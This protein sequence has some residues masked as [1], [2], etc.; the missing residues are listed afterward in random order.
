MITNAAI[1]R[2]DD[3]RF[4]LAGPKIDIYVSRGRTTLPIAQVP[5]LL[6]GDKVRMKVDLPATQLNPLLLIVA[7]VRDTTNEPPDNWF[8][9]IE[10][11]RQPPE[12][13]T[14]V[15]P[16][17]AQRALLF[18]A[19]ETGG[20]FKTLRS[21]VKGNPGVF[22]R[23]DEDL[24]KASFE[25]QRIERYL[26]GMQPVAQLETAVIQARSA[27]LATALALKPNAACFKQPVEDQV[28]CLTQVSTPLLLDDGHAQT[29]A[30]AISTGASSNFI[31]EAA[32]TDNGTY[33]AYVGTLVDLVHLVSLLRT[34]QYRY[35]PAI[36]FPKG[37]TLNL[38]LNAPPSFNNPKSV[39]V[40]GLP[41]IQSAVFPP[42]RV[43]TPLP[44]L[45]MMKPSTTLSLLGA[46]L[47]FS[48]A[49]AHDLT[50]DI[51]HGGAQSRISLTPDPIAG[52]LV[53]TGIMLQSQPG[54]PRPG[55]KTKVNPYITVGGMLHGFWGFDTLDGLRLTV[56]PVPGR[57]WKLTGTDAAIAGLDVHITMEGEGT[58]CIKEITLENK[59]DK[60]E[61]V[62]FKNTEAP[63][64]PSAINLQIPLA[65]HQPGAYSLVIQ[66]YG[67][68]R[69]DTLPLTVYSGAVHFDHL[70]KHP[71]DNMV[72]LFGKGLNSVF[73]ITLG[74][75]VFTT[76][77]L[78]GKDSGRLELYASGPA[79]ETEAREAAV[80]LND[81]RVMTVRAV[82]A[83]DGSELQLVSMDS[84]PNRL[85]DE[86]EVQLDAKKDIALHGTL[87][88]V[89]Q[90]VGV[91]PRTQTVEVATAD[92]SV[93]TMLSLNT[94]RLIL[95]DDHT[96]VASLDLGKA[97]GESA[98]GT[99]RMRAVPGDGTF[100]GW[101]TLGTLVRTP[102]IV[103]VRCSEIEV[104]TCVISGRQ[105]FLA[106]GFDTNEDLS[107]EVIV[108]EGFDEPTFSMPIGAR[109]ETLY[110]RLRDDPH[111]V[112]TF[113]I[114][115]K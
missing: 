47:V 100:G 85:K 29:V 52:G 3:A 36:S 43:P 102:H 101:I 42:W 34:A 59:T 58:A 74:N 83:D 115:R 24:N 39:I 84:V 86:I 28:D 80:K 110:I 22:I 103:A 105:L 15:V 113:R 14:I 66:Q 41:V 18:V 4:D 68:P 48:T 38:K 78:Q 89:V 44:A 10:T 61:T 69:K 114:P 63:S 71:D 17:G 81:G 112:A 13:T 87:N 65:H 55:M 49:F 75:Q 104:P 27:K 33:S 107:K 7:F 109:I 72:A 1:L 25:Q 91:F 73:S 95:E 16:D 35:I 9:K 57:N 51:D 82:A 31:T 40:V 94:D 98:F 92:G 90:S 8:T 37:A 88:F 77:G 45:C 23:A 111:A 64:F 6:A 76:G 5:N 46:P 26:T 2:A 93:S 30:G 97:F 60:P 96:A 106:L 56:Q 32:T 11:W 53:A 19:P 21:A 20:D 12:G 108:P 67:S 50:L 99:L 62:V 54:G 79:T 70:V